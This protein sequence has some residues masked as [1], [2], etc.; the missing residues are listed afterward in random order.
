[1]GASPEGH[2]HTISIA[3]STGT[4]QLTLAAST[5]YAITA[6]GSSYIFTTPPNTT[7]TFNSTY[8]ASTN[9]AAT[10]ADITW[11]NVGSKPTTL[12]GYGI[13]DAAASGHTH[14]VSITPSTT[15]VYSITGVGT[16]NVPTKIDTTK[17][18]GG[19]FTRGTFN[20]G[21]GS[22]T[23]GSFSGGSGSFTQGAFSGGSLT[24]SINSTDSKQLDITFTAATHGADSHTH[25]AATHGADSHTHTAAT[26]GADSFTAASLGTGFYTAGTASTVPT[27]SQVSNLWNGYTAASAS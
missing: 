22:F 20:G 27:R 4:N 17:F 21:S 5:K 19:S 18:N 12:S 23:Q 24:M 11:S 2:T 13:T 3:T 9:K 1:M 26:H 15:S 25:V 8:N 6:G 7:Y 10:M 16:A 14:T